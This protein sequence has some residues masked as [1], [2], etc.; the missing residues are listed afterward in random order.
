MMPQLRH[1]RRLACAVRDSTR[2]RL[3]RWLVLAAVRLGGRYP[4]NVAHHYPAASTTPSDVAE[5]LFRLSASRGSE[6]YRVRQH[7]L[8]AFVCVLV[9]DVRSASRGASHDFFQVDDEASEVR[10]QQHL[11]ESGAVPQ[12]GG[13]AVGRC[14]ALLS[15]G[16]LLRSG[17]LGEETPR[18][19]KLLQMDRSES[20]SRTRCTASRID[21][22]SLS[23]STFAP[24][25]V[26]HAPIMEPAACSLYI[27]GDLP[28]DLCSSSYWL[29][30]AT[31]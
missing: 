23:S 2:C 16:L 18:S 5:Q 19:L 13:S 27:G 12:R 25:A 6:L 26:A 20:P 11:L 1:R 9:N 7:D 28:C 8:E 29:H 30:A 22:A 17:V 15:A 21:V 24:V 3:A 10:P 31:V 14:R 4:P